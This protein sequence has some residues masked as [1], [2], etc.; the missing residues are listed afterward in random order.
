MSNIVAILDSA[1]PVSRGE[2]LDAF[3][4]GLASA[5]V[6]GQDTRVLY[7]WAN[8]DYSR[9]PGLAQE[10]ISNPDVSVI[11]AAGGPVTAIEAQ[12]LTTTKPII[13]TTV[14]NPVASELVQSLSAPG[15][16][17]TGTFGH[18][19]ELDGTRLKALCDLTGSGTIGILANPNRPHP[20]SANAA[21]QKGGLEGKAAALGRSAVVL[22]VGS[23]SQIDGAFATLNGNVSGLL[24]TADPFFNSRRERVIA[25]A[26]NLAVPAI[27][28][29]SGFV[30]AGGLMSYGPSKAEGY[31]NAGEYA[32]RIVKQGAQPATL[33]VRETNSFALV[34][35]DATALG[36]NLNLS[37]SAFTQM[38][39]NLGV[40]DIRHI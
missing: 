32:G 26:A 14:T 31:F 28:Q 15:G 37:G 8:N 35:N 39:S 27:F 6:D 18:T 19:T 17:L 9:L 30:T 40:T 21:G 4:S 7:A 16:N 2:E 38:V 25:L 13:F 12:K 29:W 24:V 23:D 1:S 36:L 5:G 11:V 34:V 33:P 3:F 20:K 10:L 22:D